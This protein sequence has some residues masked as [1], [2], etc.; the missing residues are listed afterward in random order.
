MNSNSKHNPQATGKTSRRNFIKA[1]L[2]A[3]AAGALL[4]TGFSS[5]ERADDTNTTLSA[6]GKRKKVIGEY[7]PDNL[8]IARRV[9][10]D[11]SDTDLLLLK[12]IGLRWAGVIFG[13][14]GDL[15]YMRRAQERFA[16]FGIKIYAGRHFAYRNLK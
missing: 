13:T 4:A 16:R 1:P 9:S 6:S 8:K 15:D 5:E 7:D 2:V 14:N 12:Q 10:A 11:I 3:G